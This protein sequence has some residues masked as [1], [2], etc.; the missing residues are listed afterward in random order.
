MRAYATESKHAVTSYKILACLGFLACIKSLK[1]SCLHQRSRHLRT[2]QYMRI[3]KVDTAG[4]A[5]RTVLHVSSP[6]RCTAKNVQLYQFFFKYAGCTCHYHSPPITPNTSLFLQY[7]QSSIHPFSLSTRRCIDA[8][9]C[10]S[11]YYMLVC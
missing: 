6:H 11:S 2:V 7:V 8:R 9:H 5:L 4:S 10:G 3:N 1:N